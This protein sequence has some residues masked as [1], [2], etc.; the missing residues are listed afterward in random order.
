MI[1]T[2]G[3]S[4]WTLEQLKKVMDELGITL[5]VD[6]RS[7][8]YGR[9][10]P[11]FNRPGLIRAFGRRYTWKGDVLGGKY[12][13]AKEEGIDWLVVEHGEGKTL[14]LMCVE[15]DPRKCHRLLDIGARLLFIHVIA[16]VPLL[17][18]GTQKTTRDYLGYIGGE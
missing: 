3:Y 16:A 5:L 17:H 11:A 10:N 7:I 15:W 1:Y 18:D 8:P 13:P 12:G 14:L 6:V 2:F 9:V 4:K